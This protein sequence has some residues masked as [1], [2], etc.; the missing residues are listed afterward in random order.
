M[1][2]IDFQ[3]LI[4]RSRCLL[5]VPE[6]HLEVLAVRLMADLL[7]TK[8]PMADVS[9]DALLARSRPFINLSK[10]ELLAIMVYLMTDVAVSV[11][12]VA[13]QGA[14]SLA[15]QPYKDQK[16]QYL[17]YL[18]TPGDRNGGWFYYDELSASV[19]DGVD[20]ILPTG[21]NPLDSGRWLRSPNIT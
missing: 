8:Y 11:D 13:I 14:A 17:I 12:G 15:D 20:V 6:L 2:Q 10:Q 21:K 18:D 4:N 5:C 1:S 7:L 9:V 16:L 19:H 3:A